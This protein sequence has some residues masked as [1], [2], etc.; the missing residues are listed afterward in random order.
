[1]ELQ[2]PMLLSA[3]VVYPAASHSEL[4]LKKTSCSVILTVDTQLSLHGHHQHHQQTWYNAEII[5]V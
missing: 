1:M 3:E 5:N 4:L 2:K